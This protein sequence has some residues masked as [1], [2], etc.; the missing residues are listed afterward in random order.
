MDPTAVTKLAKHKSEHSLRGKTLKF[1][2][3]LSVA[4]Q[5]QGK[6]GITPQ[7][8]QV[9]TKFLFLW[10][11]SSPFPARCPH[12]PAA[13]ICSFLNIFDHWKM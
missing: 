1:D 7:L 8:Y 5:L 11:P 2:T 4:Q 12:K 10:L 6:R 9:C 13:S 3:L